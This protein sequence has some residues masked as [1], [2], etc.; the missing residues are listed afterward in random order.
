MD[1]ELK[2]VEKEGILH[3]VKSSDWVTPI[4]PVVKPNGT[5]RIC[6]NYKVNVNPQLETKEY[7][8]PCI[9]DIF[10]KLARGQ[11][12]TKIDLKQAYH[13]MEVE[14]GSQEY[15]TVNTPQGLYQYNCLVFGITSA[16]AISQRAINQVLDRV[17]GTSCI[18]DDMIITCKDDQEHLDHLEEVGL[19]ANHEKYEF[20]QK[21]IT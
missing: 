6:G 16:S 13:Q 20:F 19:W 2:R 3:K 8:L 18:L 1:A 21:K 15:W 17:E 10:A 9:D 4:V 5:V 12:F 7:P 11:K 14:E